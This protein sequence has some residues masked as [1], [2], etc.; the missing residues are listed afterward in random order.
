[1]RKCAGDRKNERKGQRKN[2]N[3]VLS[4]IRRSLM[5]ESRLKES[6]LIV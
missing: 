3:I 1:M 4:E 6:I 2:T 5:L